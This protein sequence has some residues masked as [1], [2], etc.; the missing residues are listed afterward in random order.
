[1]SL[2]LWRAF[3]VAE[4][5]LC[6]TPGPAVLF[7]SSSS[8][9]R[10][11]RPGL[12]A[13]L[14]ILAGNTF[15]FALSA[16][17]VAAVI[18]ASARLFSALKWAGSA[19]LVWV[20]LRMLLTRARPDLPALPQPVSRSFVRGFVVQTSNAKALIF[21][22]ALLPQFID[23]AGPVAFQVFVL[24]TSSIAIEFLALSLYVALAVRARRLAGTRWSNSLERLGGGVLVAAG[25]R[26][27]MVRTP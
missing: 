20:G 9:A 5:V 21:F 18:L 27:A 15:Y 17:G 2:E 11:A 3:C 23:P 4:T 6:F 10:G 22:V 26:L 24:G 7:V 25:A 19:Y 16:T 1:M 12:S 13:A 14:G 8:I